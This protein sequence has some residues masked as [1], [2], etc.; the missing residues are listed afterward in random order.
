[1]SGTR[2]RVRRSGSPGPSQGG[3][4]VWTVWY[5]LDLLPTRFR[6]PPVA[7]ARQPSSALLCP[8]GLRGQGRVSA[9]RRTLGRDPQ[10]GG[11]LEPAVG[12]S[13]TFRF[14]VGGCDCWDGPAAPSLSTSR[15][16]LRCPRAWAV[17]GRVG[18]STTAPSTL[19]S[20]PR[21]LPEPP[22]R[23]PG[24]P[25]GSA[26]SCRPTGDGQR[27]AGSVRGTVLRVPYCTLSCPRPHSLPP[28]YPSLCR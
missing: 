23:S 22:S 12:A 2:R 19:P 27:G 14:H 13:F 8:G 10:S 21:S 1:M 9:S 20:L 25:G 3:G 16:C 7:R 4:S 11:A 24:W 28:F 26:G 17:P 18:C 5:L 15:G 6:F